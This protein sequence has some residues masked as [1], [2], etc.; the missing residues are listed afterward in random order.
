MIELSKRL[1]AWSLQETSLQAAGREEF[2]LPPDLPLL[3][4]LANSLNMYNLRCGRMAS[5]LHLYRGTGNAARSY[6]T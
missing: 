2:C 6:A 4:D 3:E 5:E 1:N